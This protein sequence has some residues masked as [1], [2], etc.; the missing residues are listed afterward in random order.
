[1]H[2]ELAEVLFDLGRKEESRSRYEEALRLAPQGVPWRTAAQAR[3]TE[4]Q[5]DMK[6]T[7]G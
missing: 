3:L 6:K 5:K 4:L 1:M 7:G 2:L